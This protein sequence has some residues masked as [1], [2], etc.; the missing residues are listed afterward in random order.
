LVLAVPI[1]LNKEVGELLNFENASSNLC[2]NRDKERGTL[3]VVRQVR[4]GIL[5]EKRQLE[6]SRRGL[7]GEVLDRLLMQ[8][9]LEVG[10]PD[11]CADERVRI[12][13]PH[14]LAGEERALVYALAD[15]LRALL[16]A[17][18]NSEQCEDELVQV[19]LDVLLFQNLQKRV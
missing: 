10:S 18:E 8:G 11:V 7:C 12:D 6:L 2:S 13:H 19:A 4:D 3:G 17:K 9:T 16:I 1:A 5:G 15:L 14:Q